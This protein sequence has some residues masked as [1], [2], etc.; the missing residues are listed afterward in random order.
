MGISAPAS[1]AGVRAQPLYPR[2]RRPRYALALRHR[3]KRVIRLWKVLHLAAP[4]TYERPPPR[5]PGNTL[6]E[7][8]RNVVTAAQKHRDR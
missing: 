5:I 7:L 2:Q 6:L 8:A 4:G 3:R 1:S